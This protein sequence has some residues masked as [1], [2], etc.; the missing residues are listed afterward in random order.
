MTSKA[1]LLLF[2]FDAAK[3]L[4]KSYQN[5]FELCCTKQFQQLGFCNQLDT[6]ISTNLPSNLFYLEINEQ[7]HL[8]NR[9][10]IFNPKKKNL[11]YLLFAER[12][13]INRSEEY[14]V[15]IIYCEPKQEKIMNGSISFKAANGWLS[16]DL[17]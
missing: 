17:L 2:E 16:S 7:N 10:L 3:Y 12:V 9:N 14:Y 6:V 8:I 4:G 5:Q 13:N 11:F 1:K 15:A